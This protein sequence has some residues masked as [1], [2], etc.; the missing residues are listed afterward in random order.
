MSAPAPP[1]PPG[2]HFTRSKTHLTATPGPPAEEGAL[3]TGEP[4]L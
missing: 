2:K 4:P 1:N 3:P